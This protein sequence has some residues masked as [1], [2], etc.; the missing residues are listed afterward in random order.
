MQAKTDDV[1]LVAGLG[2]VSVS[3]V[4]D[5]IGAAGV[6]S[7]SSADAD[8]DLNACRRV[9][10][11]SDFHRCALAGGAPSRAVRPTIGRAVQASRWW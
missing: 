6:T 8:G 7:R 9:G 2:V 5:R 10:G 1:L 4:S 11:H 3:T